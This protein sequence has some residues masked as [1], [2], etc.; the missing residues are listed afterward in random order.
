[1]PV[2]MNIHMHDPVDQISNKK[3]Y[4]YILIIYIIKSSLFIVIIITHKQKLVHPKEN[5]MDWTIFFIFIFPDLFYL[6][7]FAVFCSYHYILLV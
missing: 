7:D 3:I 2:Y 6:K 5:R 1:M 4:W